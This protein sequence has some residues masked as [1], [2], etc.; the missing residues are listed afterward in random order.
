MKYTISLIF[1]FVFS[2]FDLYAQKNNIAGEYSLTGVME[3][4]S[5]IQLNEDSTFR[6]YFS[7]GAL[8]RFGSG[9]WSVFKNS[10]ILNSKPYPGKD[11]KMISSS[12][13][14][15][16]YTTIKIEDPNT[17]LYPLVYCLV[18]RPDGD[19]IINADE[20]GIIVVQ[21]AMDS[22]HLLC[23][24]CTE[25]ITTFPISPQKHNSYTFHFEQWITEVF[26]KSFTLRYAGNHL[27]GKH[28]LLGDKEYN[29]IRV[30]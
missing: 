28:P 6:F 16:N 13:I 1:I 22:I 5:G 23:Q 18:K 14:N 24:L 29:F 26:F 12:S 9:K 20:K 8:D 15:N 11:F 17:N 7:Y 27:V 3:T 30:K 10:V 25:R 4:A 2:T 21:N 19:T